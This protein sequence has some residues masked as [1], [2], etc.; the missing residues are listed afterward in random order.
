[1]SSSIKVEEYAY[2]TEL[3]YNVSRNKNNKLLLDD[4]SSE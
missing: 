3:V 4:I 2:L 1:M